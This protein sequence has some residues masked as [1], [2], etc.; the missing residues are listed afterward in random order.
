M[1]RNLFDFFRVG[2]DKKFTVCYYNEKLLYTQKLDF[3]FFYIN[4]Y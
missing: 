2:C 4:L 3:F 1:L